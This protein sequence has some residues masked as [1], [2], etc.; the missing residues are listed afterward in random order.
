M[1]SLLN[2]RM[3]IHLATWVGSRSTPD[4]QWVRQGFRFHKDRGAREG[5]STISTADRPYKKPSR[6]EGTI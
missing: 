3:P 2:G 6:L 5:G 4:S 1:E